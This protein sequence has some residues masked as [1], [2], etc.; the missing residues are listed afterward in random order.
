MITACLLLKAP[1]EGLVKTRLALDLGFPRATAIYRAL[2]ERQ[3]KSL[4]SEWT[5]AIHF[6]PTDAGSELSHWLR[7]HLPEGSR[8]IPQS[9]G[10]LGVR[11][12]TS[13]HTEF[14]HGARRLFLLG[15]DCPELNRSYLDDAAAQLDTHDLVLGPAIDGGYVLLGLKAPHPGLFMKI[16]W[17]T[18]KV[19]PQT[20]AAAASLALTT[21]Q[22]TTLEDVDDLASLKRQTNFLNEAGIALS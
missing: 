2:V 5:V 4:P 13:V 17:S 1:R 19:L 11:L 21:S 18:S 20:L 14:S 9:E 10:D 3:L 16:A 15:G 7:P 22:L 6:A 8:F 12:N